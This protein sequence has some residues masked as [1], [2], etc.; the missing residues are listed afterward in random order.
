MAKLNMFCSPQ[1]KGFLSKLLA[2]IGMEGKAG[3]TTSPTTEITALFDPKMYL[4]SSLN[5]IIGVSVMLVSRYLIK[6]A[7]WD[8]S[9][10]TEVCNS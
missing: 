7:P 3:P 10:T 9:K 1:S 8:K 2:F 5:G 6:Y 4:L